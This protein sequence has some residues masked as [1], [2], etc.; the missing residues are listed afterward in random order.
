MVEAPLRTYL[1]FDSA[2]ATIDEAKKVFD[3]PADSAKWPEAEKIV[4]TTLQ[5]LAESLNIQNCDPIT[6]DDKTS[7]ATLEYNLKTG[8]LLQILPSGQKRMVENPRALVDNAAAI[9]P[10]FKELAITSI[11]AS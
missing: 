2:K 7:S 8:K 4:K 1:G 5:A 3:T 6:L 9:L 10:I 11:Q